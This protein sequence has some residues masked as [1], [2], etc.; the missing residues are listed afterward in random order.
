[1]PV[2]FIL[3]RIPLNLNLNLSLARALPGVKVT[4]QWAVFALQWN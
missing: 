3:E 4:C 1:M 2:S